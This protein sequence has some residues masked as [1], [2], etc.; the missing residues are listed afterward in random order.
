MDKA[1][2]E[3]LLMAMGT[4]LT[5]LASRGY[6]NVSVTSEAIM[7]GDNEVS[8]EVAMMLEYNRWYYDDDSNSWKFD[9]SQ[10]E[11]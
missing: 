1:Y 6:E 10:L 3:N 11:E 7:A 2:E 8:V 5:L 4:G 9:L